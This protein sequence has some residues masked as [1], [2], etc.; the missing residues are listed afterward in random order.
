MSHWTL[1]FEMEMALRILFAGLLGGLLGWE[2]ERH[3]IYSAGIRT[4]SAIA[5]GACVFGIIS[6]YIS[7]DPTH[8]AANVITG[9]GFL[10]GG[11][12]FRHE[13]KNYISGVTT[14]A[15][16]WAAASVGLAVAY[17]MYFIAL[18]TTILIY[19]LLYLPRLPWWHKVSHPRRITSAESS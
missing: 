9:I 17:G 11:I 7:S 14:A 15:T 19:L 1:L 5:I 2:R 16:L 18:S 10:G 3:G 12:I 6:I 8:V 4:Y 13:G